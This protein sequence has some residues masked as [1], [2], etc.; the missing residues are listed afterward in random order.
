MAEEAL[1]SVSTASAGHFSARCVRPISRELQKHNR[2]KL[3]KEGGV[4][5]ERALLSVRYGGV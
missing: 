2:K 3:E 4:C 5:C 1:P